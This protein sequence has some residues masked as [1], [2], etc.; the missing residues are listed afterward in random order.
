MGEFG[1][2]VSSTSLALF[3]FVGMPVADNA[4]PSA[5]DTSL[6]RRLRW[7]LG[8]HKSVDMW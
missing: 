2:G 8:V 7:C 5:V 3:S 1:V 6:N 4:F